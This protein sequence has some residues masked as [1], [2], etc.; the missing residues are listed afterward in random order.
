MY[1]NIEQLAKSGLTPYDLINLVAIR[2]KDD[3]YMRSIPQGVIINYMSLGLIETLKSGVVRLTNKGTSFLEVIET[4][5][6]NEDISETFK[7]LIDLYESRGK[8]IGISRKEAQARLV[9]FMGNTNF[10]KKLIV[11]ITREYLDKSGD[12]TMSLC[13]FIWKPPSQAFSVHMNLKNSKMF[14]MIASKYGFNTEL[15]FKEKKNKEMDW[16]FAV[17]RLPD[18]PVKGNQDCLFTFDPKREKERL[19]SIKTYLYNRLKNWRK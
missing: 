8:D 5:G 12:Y 18:P 11:D 16:L 4:P 13:N 1:I 2:Q 19:Q 14:D 10:K 9:W 6:I 3:V 15:Y 17:A 7:E